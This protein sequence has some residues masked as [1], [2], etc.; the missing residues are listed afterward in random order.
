MHITCIRIGVLRWESY[1]FNIIISA[2]SSSQDALT[3]S[4]S[5]RL[6]PPVRSKWAK[7]GG[8]NILLFLA[9]ED[10]MIVSGSH[11][12]DTR[13]VIT[14]EILACDGLF[15]LKREAVI[16]QDGSKSPKAGVH[17]IV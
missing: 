10:A 16:A 12:Y 5:H 7:R 6:A 4:L 14:F 17:F 2:S 8:L 11:G 15:R 9:K 13:R 3:A 1:A